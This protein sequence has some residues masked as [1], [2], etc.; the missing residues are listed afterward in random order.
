[1]TT[2][3]T[4]SSETRIVIVDDTPD[5]RLLMRVL[6]DRYDGYTIVGEAEN[7]LEAIELA[8]IHQ[9]DVILLD[10]AM[11]EMDGL[12]A[13][14]QIKRAATSAEV[15]VLSTFDADQ[16][17]AAAVGAG[18]SSYVRKGASPEELVHTIAATTGRPVPELKAR[19]GERRAERRLVEDAGDDPSRIIARTA[20][21][22]RNPAIILTMLAEQLLEARETMDPATVDSLLQAIVRQAAALDQL[23]DDLLTSTRARRGALSVRPQPLD[24]GEVLAEVVAAQEGADISLRCPSGIGVMADRLRLQQMIG[25]LISNA[26]KYGAPPIEVT[27]T[28]LGREVEIRVID[29]G[30][31][32]PAHFQSEMFREYTRAE[33]NVGSGTGLGLFIVDSLA[34]AHGG[35][36]RYEPAAVATTFCLALPRAVLPEPSG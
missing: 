16:M 31:G 19:A 20:H 33:P 24:V 28:P 10:L 27:C 12:E 32:V 29:H 8:Q 15:I 9:P 17:A 5:M 26:R 35:S 7:G 23:T 36:I 1:L 22:L 3:V 14:P 13:L 11:P 21:E 34:R 4:A 30:P 18:A 6:L 2:P 25:N